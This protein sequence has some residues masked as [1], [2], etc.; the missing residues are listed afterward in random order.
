[1]RKYANLVK[2]TETSDGAVTWINPDRVVSVWRSGGE[3]FIDTGSRTVTV[4]GPIKTTLEILEYGRE[5]P[6]E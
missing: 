5:L 6:P 1:M 3:V 2:F 4:P